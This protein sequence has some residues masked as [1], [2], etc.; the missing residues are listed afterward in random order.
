MRNSET[1]EAARKLGVGTLVIGSVRRSPTVIRVSAQLLDGS[2]GAERW[3]ET[4]DRAPGDVLAIQADIAEKV[5][6]ALSIQL[7][8]GERASLTEGGTSNA[9]AHDLYLKAQALFSSVNTQAG[10]R[11]AIGLLDAA[12]ALDPGFANALA[13]KSLYLS[14]DLSTFGA[15]EVNLA[16]GYA[17][18]ERAAKKAIEIS[19]RLS[20][21]YAALGGLARA[22]LDGATA[23]RMYELALA[24]NPRGSEALVGQARLLGDL[25]R[26]APAL[27]LAAQLVTLDPLD[28]ALHSFQSLIYYYARRYP[29]AINSARHALKLSPQRY[30]AYSRIGDALV[31]LGRSKE[32]AVEYAHMPAEDP[33]RLVGLSISSA[34]L[35]D[36]AS[37]DRTL[38]DLISHFGEGFSYQ[39]GEIHAMRGEPDAA[40]TALH[41]AFELRDPGLLGV[42]IDPFLDSIRSDARF[43]KL[44]ADLRLP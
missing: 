14:Q 34:K 28:P 31:M 5:A 43:A 22:R 20:L 10:E 30:V 13:L 27:K 18:A 17:E 38:R 11:E 26:V 6:R 23:V 37:S 4:Y 15:E 36:M 33:W 29:D 40:F 8:G 3:A 16:S 42:R 21:G 7:G 9:A 1:T 19:P 2:D 24:Y 41:R 44:V 39:F 12:I 35:G 32:A 25:G